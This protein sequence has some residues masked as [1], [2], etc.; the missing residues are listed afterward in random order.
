MLYTEDDG[1]ATTTSAPANK[2]SLLLSKL[3]NATS[4]IDVSG[5]VHSALEEARSLDPQVHSNR[6]SLMPSDSYMNETLGEADIAKDALTGEGKD[7]FNSTLFEMYIRGI[8]RNATTL[9]REQKRAI[10]G[11][12]VVY[13]V[14]V[15]LLYSVGKLGHYAYTTYYC[16]SFLQV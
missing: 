3:A 11:D 9:S 8:V 2:M 5:I 13:I 10:E 6:Q 16:K 1:E 12:P 14:A 15:L 7:C 4:H